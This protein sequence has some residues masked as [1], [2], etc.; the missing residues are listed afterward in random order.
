MFSEDP[1]TAERSRYECTD[2]L[3]RVTTDGSIGSCPECGG[4]MRNVAVPRE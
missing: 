2:C 4:R 3:H 1:Y